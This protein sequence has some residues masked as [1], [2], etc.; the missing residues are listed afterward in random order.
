MGFTREGRY[1]RKRKKTKVSE[2]KNEFLS[3]Q[4]EKHEQGHIWVWEENFSG[5]LFQKQQEL[6]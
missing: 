2:N 1:V 5:K 3:K 4:E 6:H